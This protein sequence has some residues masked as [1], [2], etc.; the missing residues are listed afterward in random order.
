M[1]LLSSNYS[2]RSAI[3]G[4]LCRYTSFVIISLLA[5]CSES[6]ETPED[7]IRALIDR[8]EIAAEEKDSNAMGELV[9]DQYKDELNNDRRRIINILRV[10]FLRHQN[11]HLLIQIKSIKILETGR[12]KVEL[13]V[14]M[15][16]Q[17]VPDADALIDLNVDLYQFQINFI[18]IEKGRWQVARA[19]WARATIEDFI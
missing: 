3:R 4:I 16:G 2:I 15:A 10:Q 8:A 18:E 5:A 7:Q 9:A 19:K 12:A 1:P 14:A 17:H 6:T 13:L 11:V